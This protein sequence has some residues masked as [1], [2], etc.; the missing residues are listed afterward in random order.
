MFSAI[1][2]IAT[3]TCSGIAGVVACTGRFCLPFFTADA[4][5]LPHGRSRAGD[6]HLNFY[7]A[8]DN[9]REWCGYP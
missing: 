1:S 7:D 6:R 9:L 2:A 3:L 5:Q 8:R 4:R